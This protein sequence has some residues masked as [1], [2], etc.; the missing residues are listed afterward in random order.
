M[1]YAVLI[2]RGGVSRGSSLCGA[3]TLFLKKRKKRKKTKK[4]KSRNRYDVCVCMRVCA[5][6][7][8]CTYVYNIYI[9]YYTIF[10]VS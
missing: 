10:I 3:N 4:K 2:G 6:V 9:I 5:G 8:V 1:S 7:R